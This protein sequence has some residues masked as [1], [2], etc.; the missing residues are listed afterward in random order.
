MAF[1]KNMKIVIVVLL[2]TILGLACTT[3]DSNT[4]PKES[5]TDYSLAPIPTP[6]PSPSPTPP[7]LESEQATSQF[8][9]GASGLGDS[10]FPNLGNGG[11][12][13]ERYVIEVEWDPEEK[14]LRGT[15][16][17]EAKSTDNIL[18]F[19]VDFAA[20]SMQIS[21]V[22]VNGIRALFT[23]E[24]NEI[25]VIPAEGLP[26]GT[27]FNARFVY[28]GSPSLFLMENTSSIIGGWFS[29]DQGVFVSGEPS[30]S[31]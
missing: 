28:E 7:L 22:T 11:Y 5:K 18:S 2:C 16:V 15:T 12:D 27:N 1:L 6:S 25:V 14:W 3:G 26:S 31:R 10:Y 23:A 17:I 13:V 24:E 30:S 9:A 4:D 8:V 29:S 21:E 20:N 19:N